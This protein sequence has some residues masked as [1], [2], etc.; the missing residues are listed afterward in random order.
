VAAVLAA[1]TTMVAPTAA[2]QQ[3]DT[4]NHAMVTNT[5]D[6]GL[7][8]RTDPDFEAKSIGAVP[9]GT[10]VQVVDGPR[11]GS[12]T[13]WYLVQPPASLGLAAGYANAAYLAPLSADGTPLGRVLDAT[14]TGYANGA[15]G[16]AVSS[17]TASG[18]STHWGTVAADWRLFPLGTRLMI[19][20]FGDTVFVVEDTGSGVR[21]NLIDVWFEDLA[22]AQAFGTQ[23]RQITVL[24]PHN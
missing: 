20:G 7:G 6:A 16:G 10:V 12:R 11:S 17:T 15:D 1:A 5:G 14:V 18:T 9:E 2:A 21:G 8:L 13:T 19:E 23:R 24:P 22:A 3:A 4:G